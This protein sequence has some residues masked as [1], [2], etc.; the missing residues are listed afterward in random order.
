MFGVLVAFSLHVIIG[1][2]CFEQNPTKPDDNTADLKAINETAKKIEEVFLAADTTQLKSLL[3]D[4]ATGVYSQYIS[5]IQTVMND[6]GKAI[7]NRTLVVATQNYAEFSFKAEGIEYSFALS[8]Q[9]DNSWLLMR[10]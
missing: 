9:D 5:Q 8:R 3:T 1:S 7:Q 4:A 10:F 2:S 6:Y